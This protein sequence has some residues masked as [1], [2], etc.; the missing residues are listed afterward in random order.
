MDS[1]ENGLLVVKDKEE[2][3]FFLR[4]EEARIRRWSNGC[5]KL[6]CLFSSSDIDNDGWSSR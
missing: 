6:F 3:G 4:D 2:N 5:S 1:T